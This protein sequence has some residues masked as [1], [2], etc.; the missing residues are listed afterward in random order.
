MGHG[1]GNKP[2]FY[3][4]WAC[5]SQVVLNVL[6]LGLIVS[7]KQILK[8]YILIFVFIYF[9]PFGKKIFNF[10]FFKGN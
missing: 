10:N 8:K 6:I 2:L 3:H 5:G 1:N 7:H 4:I 9:V